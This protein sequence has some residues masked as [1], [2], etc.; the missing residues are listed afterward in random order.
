MSSGAMSQWSDSALLFK[1]DSL[2]R[3]A[4][5]V[6][7]RVANLSNERFLL[8][9]IWEVWTVNTPVTGRFREEDT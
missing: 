1:S 7:N 8:F 4:G 9:G 3:M 6:R 2:L 5:T